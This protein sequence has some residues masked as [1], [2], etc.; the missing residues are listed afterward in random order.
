MMGGEGKGWERNGWRRGAEERGTEGQEGGR[1]TH[2]NPLSQ[3]PSPSLDFPVIR[4]N[5]CP[6]LPKTKLDF[7]HSRVVIKYSLQREGQ[8]WLITELCTAA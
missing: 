8:V 3:K 5:K 4:D 2:M 1:S 7:Y 6:F